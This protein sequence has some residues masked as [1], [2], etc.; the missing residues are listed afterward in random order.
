LLVQIALT[1]PIIYWMTDLPTDR[2]E[3]PFFF[4]LLITE[5]LLLMT[6]LAFFVASLFGDPLAAQLAAI[7]LLLT[8]MVFCGVMV[9]LESLP[10][11][12]VPMYYFSFFKYSSEG[13]LATQFY[14]LVSDICVPGGKP[15]HGGIIG[16]FPICTYDGSGHVSQIS[17]VRVSAAEFVLNDFA[18]DYKFDH[19]WLDAG[20]LAV[21]IIGLRLVT[22]VITLYVNH[23]KR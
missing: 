3:R 2:W 9:P 8:L 17:G 22:Y 4:V 11:P 15:A 23:Q 10:K 13:L 14:E 7:G 18:K 1:C 21:W 16:R 12:Y 20:V 5:L 19:R 6:S